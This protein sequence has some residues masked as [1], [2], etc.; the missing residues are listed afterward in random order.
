MRKEIALSLVFLVLILVGCEVQQSPEI[1]DINPEPVKNGESSLPDLS[2][3]NRVVE[4]VIKIENKQ[5]E[6]KEE[7]KTVVKVT[8]EPV[9]EVVKSTLEVADATSDIQKA[10]DD[11]KK[12]LEDYKSKT[13]KLDECTK[14]CAGDD[15]NI[16]YVKDQW[17]LTCYQLYYY[18]G[19][20]ALDK[21]ITECTK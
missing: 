14:L 13:S 2:S 18:A 4:P 6:V 21:Q 15:Y 12:A 3:S 19:E 1:K 9:K 8:T 17:Y 20:S 7:V 16:P 11:S 10:L 5:K